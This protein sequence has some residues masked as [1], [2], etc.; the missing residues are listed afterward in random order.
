VRDIANVNHRVVYLFDWQIVQRLQKFRAGVQP[1]IVFAV[2]NFLGAGWE[3]DVLGIERIADVRWGKSFA[4]KFL[5]I[6]ID[7]DLARLSTVWERDLRAL[8]GC[9]LCADEI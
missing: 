1:H 8:D 6:D 4:E 5:R 3:D 2:A 7:H 9:Q